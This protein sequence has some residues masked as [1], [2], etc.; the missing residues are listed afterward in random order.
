M[1]TEFLLLSLIFSFTADVLFLKTPFE[2]TAIL[3]FIAVQYCHRRL[4]N[5]SLLSFT[6]GGFS[7]MFFLLLLSYFWHIKS[8]LLTAA[9][10]FYIALLTW[11]LCS[12]FTV[13]RQN[14]PTLLRICLVMLLACDLNVGFFNLPRFCGDLPHLSCFLL[15]A[16]RRKADLAFLS[17]KP[18]NPAL[19]VLSLPQ[20]ESIFRSSLILLF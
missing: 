3:F 5:G 18:V 4:Q 14:T 7:G 13:K 15:H 12:S 20:E 10:F 8:S 19:P 9:A 1:K 6:A 16:H 17:S 2:L 11:N